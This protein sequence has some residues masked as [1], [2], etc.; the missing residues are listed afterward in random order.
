MSKN[1]AQ[2]PFLGPIKDARGRQHRHETNYHRGRHRTV[3]L[4]SRIA[5]FQL[6]NQSTFTYADFDPTV[7]MSEAV[8]GGTGQISDDAFALILLVCIRDDASATTAA[9]GEL[10][11]KGVT[12]PSMYVNAGHINNSF[13]CQQGVVGLQES[14]KRFQ[15]QLTAS[16]GGTA[17]LHVHIV[18]YIEQIS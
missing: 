4:P 2:N 7:Y 9:Y 16:G 3:M 13:V 6:N 11:E 14:T 12:N 18:G 8:Y 10:R 5:A 1:K 17:D 15:Y